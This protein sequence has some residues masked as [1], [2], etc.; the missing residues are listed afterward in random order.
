MGA[1][2]SVVDRRSASGTRARRRRHMRW[3]RRHYYDKAPWWRREVGGAPVWA[4][5]LVGLLVLSVVALAFMI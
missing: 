5:G 2:R 3:I 4:I 1:E